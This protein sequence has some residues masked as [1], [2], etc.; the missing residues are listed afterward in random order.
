[1]VDDGGPLKSWC[2]C[3]L[4]DFG[5]VADGDSMLVIIGQVFGYE[6]THVGTMSQ[7]RTRR[8]GDAKRLV[9]QAWC[10]TV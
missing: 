8:A 9:Q 2:S 6:S 1:M 7:C 4:S 5:L 10:Q 3:W